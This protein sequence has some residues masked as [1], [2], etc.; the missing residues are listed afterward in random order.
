MSGPGWE[1]QQECE[2]QRWTLLMEALD[3]AV[4]GK[5]TAEQMRFIARECG[6][7]DYKPHAERRTARVG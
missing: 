4:E 1:Q 5:A 2:R 7:N 3:A 6:V